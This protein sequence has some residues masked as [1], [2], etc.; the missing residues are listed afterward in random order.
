MTRAHG[1]IAAGILSA[2]LPCALLLG[3]QTGNSKAGDKNL[4]AR[5]YFTD[6]VLVNQDGQEMRFFSDL[7]EGKTVMVITFFTTCTGICPPMNR[8]LEQIQSWLDDR[9]GKDVH[10]LAISVDPLHDT[11]PRM[12]EYA[13]RY[14]AKPGWYF[15]GGKKENV[16]LALK[17]L[18]QYVEAKDDHSPIMII[19]NQRTGLW[20][21]A[22]ALAKIEDLIK[23]VDSVVN[24]KP[25]EGS[26][27]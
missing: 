16:D 22:L 4:A 6:V 23:I 21:K 20:K 17:K 7:I 2:A 8:N 27:N 14:H 13:R 11:P 5:T 24:D 18:G 19:G 1:V 25:Q 12:K 26:S 15:L 10:M 3:A 9:L